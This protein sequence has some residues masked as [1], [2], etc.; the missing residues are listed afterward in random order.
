MEKG[1]EVRKL[2]L[3]ATPAIW[4]PT[5][6]TLT[7]ISISDGMNGTSISVLENMTPGGP[8]QGT[9]QTREHQHSASP[10][11]PKEGAIVSPWA[12]DQNISPVGH[13][14][15]R[16][17]ISNQPTPPTPLPP[18]GVE[19]I[20]TWREEQKPVKRDS[21]ASVPQKN[22]SSSVLSDNLQYSNLPPQ[23]YGTLKKDKKPF[24]YTPGGMDLSEIKS[25]RMAKRIMANRKNPGVSPRPKAELGSSSPLAKSETPVAIRQPVLPVII[26]QQPV[27]TPLSNPSYPANPQSQKLPKQAHNAPN[28]GFIPIT[29]DANISQ[30]EDAIR[31]L[32]GL[33]LANNEQDPRH[34]DP[35]EQ[36]PRSL[37]R[38]HGVH[39]DSG[40]QNPGSFRQSR[41]FWVLQKLTSTDDSDVQEE[42]PPPKKHEEDEMRFSGLKWNKIPSRMFQNL[43]RMTD[44]V[45]Q[46][47]TAT[48]KRSPPP[49]AFQSNVGTVKSHAHLI[50]FQQPLVSSPKQF[51]QP[52]V[53]ASELPGEPEPRKYIGGNIPSRS[54]RLLQTLTGED[55]N[56]PGYQGTDF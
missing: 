31:Q 56:T 47:E 32:E 9:S 24:T 46:C 17:P 51:S 21:G 43:Q 11:S 2:P 54:F 49:L 36:Y 16:S 25:T 12:S 50:Q 45:D 26:N 27:L 14:F 23:L 20:P 37:P 13:D 38:N 53:S 4:S 52:E 34:Y 35:P 48:S 40:S 22:V 29:L 41:S 55:P 7:T 6:A 28:L 5:T 1:F 18:P 19:G 15:V 44:T 3:N 8:L 33:N 30:T 42:N 10:A 39:Y